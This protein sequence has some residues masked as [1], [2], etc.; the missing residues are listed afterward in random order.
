L[1]YHNRLRVICLI[2]LFSST[3]KVVSANEERLSTAFAFVRANELVIYR[4]DR[5]DTI[6]LSKN[7]SKNWCQPM[8]P[9]FVDAKGETVLFVA[10]RLVRRGTREAVN[11]E[12][13]N[14]YLFC[15]EGVQQLTKYGG[16]TISPDYSPINNSI[17]FVSNHQSRLRKLIPP[18]NSMQLY[19]KKDRWNIAKC[20]THTLGD[21]Y[22]PQW[23]PDGKKIAFAWMKEDS[24]GI[25]ILE[26]ATVRIIKVVSA[27]N[28]PTWQPDGKAIAFS[29]NGKIFVIDINDSG[30]VSEPKQLL[31]DFAGYCSFLR[32]TKAGLLFQWAHGREQGISLF[33]PETGQAQILASGSKEFGGS[34]LA[35]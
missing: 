9:I 1:S 18:T 20:L 13:T 3:A 11:I 14:L 15:P 16:F 25:Y 19:L 33:T 30:A 28:Y 34:D 31:P 17:V 7:S 24:L 32:W 21:K 27:G 35:D 4:P 8:S 23:S 29:R 2:L 10:H 22:N 6:V 12:I 26:E 5:R